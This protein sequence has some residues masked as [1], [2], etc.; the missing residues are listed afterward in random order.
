[1][2]TNL[3]VLFLPLSIPSLYLAYRLY[4]RH[5]LGTVF[6]QQI[7]LMMLYSGEKGREV[8]KELKYI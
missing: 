5:F 4:S 3:T 7:A 1:M 2:L 6:N 8:K